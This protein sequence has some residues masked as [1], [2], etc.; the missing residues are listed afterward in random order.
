MTIVLLM[1]G[2]AVVVTSAREQTIRSL[3][4]ATVNARRFGGVLLVGVGLWFIALAVWADF[5]AGVFP[6]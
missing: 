6:V 1:I 5:F 3:R 2:V 4:L